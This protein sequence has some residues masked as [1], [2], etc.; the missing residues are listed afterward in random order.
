MKG[1]KNSTR[2]QSGHSFPTDCGFSSS[3]GE[4]QTVR[5]HSR[6]APKRMAVGGYAGGGKPKPVQGKR[7][8]SPGVGGALKD[9]AKSIAEAVAP[10]SLKQRGSRV[11]SEVARA[12]EYKKGGV[13]EGSD[14]GHALTQRKNPVTDLDKARGGT[15]PLAPGFKKGGRAKAECKAVVGKA[16]AKHVATPKPRGHGVGSFSRKPMIGK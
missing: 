4:T 10:K 16:M 9:F 7:V 3:S 14:G 15:S 6:Q 1:F 5:S 13:V 12:Q 11:E 8:A 2:V